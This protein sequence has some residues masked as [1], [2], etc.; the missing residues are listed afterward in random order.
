MSKRLVHV[1]KTEKP[2]Y[3]FAIGYMIKHTLH[4]NKVFTEQILKF[5]WIAFYQNITEGIE[6]VMRRKDTCVI[7]LIMF[8]ETK[9]TIQ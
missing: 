1:Y 2:I 3:Q 8:Y 9:K 4:V 6:R 7:E 5:P